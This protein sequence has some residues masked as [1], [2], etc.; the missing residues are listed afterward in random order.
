MLR[1]GYFDNTDFTD[2]HNDELDKKLN[3]E[4]EMLE[5]I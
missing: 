3:D 2:E 4:K 5:N 1:S